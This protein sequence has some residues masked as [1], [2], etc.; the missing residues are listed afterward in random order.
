MYISGAKYID[1]ETMPNFTASFKCRSMIAMRKRAENNPY[2]AADVNSIIANTPVLIP[3]SLS[4]NFTAA[5]RKHDHANTA[6]IHNCERIRLR[7]KRAIT[8]RTLQ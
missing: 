1:A 4:Q 7:R 3:K 8:S 6:I 2:T 5:I